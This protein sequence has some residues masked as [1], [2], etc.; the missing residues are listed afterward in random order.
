[1]RLMEACLAMLERE[2]AR[3][4]PAIEQVY[5]PVTRTLFRIPDA[6]RRMRGMLANLDAPVKL[7]G[8]LP[9]MPDAVAD[10]ELVAR[11]A[12]ASTFVASL[13]LARTAEIVLGPGDDFDDMTGSRSPEHG[14]MRDASVPASRRAVSS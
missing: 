9:H 3:E 11:S 5:A 4:Q 2:E 12:V 1:M 8:F 10:R 14:Q 13:E 6:L 7:T